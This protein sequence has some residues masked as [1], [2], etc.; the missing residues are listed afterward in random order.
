MKIILSVKS[1]EEL[2]RSFRLYLVE[3]NGLAERTCQ[4]RIF[5][6]REF[7]RALRR[8][9]RG[10]P[11]G[12]ELGSSIWSQYVLGRSHKDSSAR[13]QALG[14]A[15]RSF[16]RFL[17]ASGRTDRDWAASIPRI[18]G[19]GP[20]VGLDYLS[21]REVTR[22]LASIER[23]TAA[24]I[25]NYAVLLCLVRLGLRAGEVVQLTLEQINWRAG[26]IRIGAGKVRRQRQLP[27]PSD[28]G[29]ALAKH[30]QRSPGPT[31]SRRVFDGLCSHAVST[32][33]SRALRRASIATARPGAHLLRRTFASHLVQKGA[34]LKAVADLLGHRSLN[35]TRLYA[36]VNH[37]MLLEV[38]Q[39]WP[40]EVQP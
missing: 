21:P 11:K 3:V 17:C 28:V 27:L 24:G 1:V 25:R 13:L 12:L 29:R 8:K 26:W 30:L 22:L 31:L 6:A 2:L 40:K 37:P 35:T 36:G 16:C 9:S 7:L 33:T 5:Y 10:R 15:L 32:M 18:G 20:K 23:Q 19:H 34:S 4:G 14:T 39:L 38:A